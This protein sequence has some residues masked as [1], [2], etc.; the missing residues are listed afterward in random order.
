MELKAVRIAASSV[1]DQ[2]EEKKNNFDVPKA[3]S[4]PMYSD[5]HC[6]IKAPL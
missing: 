2:T 3:E 5:M 1:L 4:L 6:C